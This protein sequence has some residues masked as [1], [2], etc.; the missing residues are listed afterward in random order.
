MNNTTVNNLG[1]I[2][3]NARYYLPEIGRF[4]SADTIVPE[5]QNPQSYNR[6]SY[7]LNN[8]VSFTDPTG[9]RECGALEGCE[10]PL[11]RE[12]QGQLEILTPS[13]PGCDPIIS[14]CDVSTQLPGFWVLQNDMAEACA[15][16]N[17]SNEA[18]WIYFGIPYMRE[19]LDSLVYDE[20]RRL[21]YELGRCA[22]SEVGF[23]LGVL[24]FPMG[25]GGTILTG[26]YNITDSIFHEDLPGA[27]I[28]LSVSLAD[29]LD[30][31]G[32][33]TPVV[34]TA[35]GADTLV[36]TVNDWETQAQ[37]SVQLRINRQV[38]WLE[39]YWTAFGDDFQYP[40]G[41]MK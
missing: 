13:T 32:V 21:C 14:I 7:V 5:P 28:V 11:A 38:R 25:A 2:Y 27:A 17:C 33:I 9:H 41:G 31:F 1:L 22:T 23:Y 37:R 6:Y 15:S 40:L 4:V 36:D 29:I 3:M 20:A 24:T 39:Y 34:N 30:T 35:F 10:D 18:L 16:G 12:P 19:Q 26:I 8:P